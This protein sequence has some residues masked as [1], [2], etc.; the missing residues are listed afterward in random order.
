[1][2]TILAYTNMIYQLLRD[3]IITPEEAESA[4]AEMRASMGLDPTPPVW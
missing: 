4:V 3:G 1:M 2:K